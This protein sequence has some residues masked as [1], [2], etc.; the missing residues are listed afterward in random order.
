MKGLIV[1]VAVIYAMGN[2]FAHNHDKKKVQHD[3]EHQHVEK[4][5]HEHDDGH[6]KDHDHKAHHPEHVDEVKKEEKK[7]K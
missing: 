6:H 3:K 7:K 5:D 4:G 1:A 2:A